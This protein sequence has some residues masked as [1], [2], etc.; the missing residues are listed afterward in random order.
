MPSATEFSLAVLP[1]ARH[2][3]IMPSVDSTSRSIRTARWLLGLVLCVVAAF[4]LAIGVSLYVERS[5][6]RRVEVI[7]GEAMPSVHLLALVRG[8]LRELDRELD[9]YYEA[10]SAA[11]RAELENELTSNL[12]NAEA[13]LASYEQLP[14]FPG[15][16]PLYQVARAAVGQ[17]GDLSLRIAAIGGG[18]HAALDQARLD[19][20]KADRA[21]ER[22]VN[23]DAM[24][25]QQLGSSIEHTR[26][27]SREVIVLLD[28]LCVLLVLF[29]ALLARRQLQ[30]TVEG[31]VGERSLAE[32]RAE[33]LSSQV[34]E[35][36]HFAGRVAH[37]VLSP[38]STAGLAFEMV[39]RADHDDSKVTRAVER[40]QSAIQRVHTL[41]DDLLAFARAGGKPEPGARA[42]LAQTIGDVTDA[43]GVEAARQRIELAVAPVPAGSVRCSPGV[44]TS[45]ISN[46]VR[47]AIR[48]MGDSAERR[49][50][51]HVS[52]VDDRFRIEVQDTGPGIPP[53]QEERIF[54]PYV[55]LGARNAGVGLGLATVDRLVRAHGGTVGVQ[56]PPGHG[57]MFWLE[58]P[59]A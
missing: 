16:A 40:G 22:V 50:D 11:E 38:L 44:L 41:V 19:I 33:E 10:A 14:S 20:D 9:L 51:V 25:G 17:L 4:L 58:L 13:E 54:E 32:Q 26:A 29:A 59:A 57:A 5:V 31:L 27:E 8:D 24:K 23:Y 36:G 12:R 39:Q 18:N 2:A 15:E 55:Q 6:T 48:Y 7:T 35:L 53:G 46:L 37:D 21:L 49:I 42:D 56:S 43:L 52:R 34:D 28:A 1:R 3:M 45:L 30:Q 47:N